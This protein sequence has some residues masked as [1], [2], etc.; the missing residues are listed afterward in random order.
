MEKPSDSNVR[1]KGEEEK[2]EIKGNK[3][4]VIDFIIEMQKGGMLNLV[5]E[6]ILAKKDEEN[7]SDTEQL[8]YRLGERN[9]Q[10]RSV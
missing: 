6:Y 2:N 7:I 4:E 10:F 9:Y 3:E 5:N 1:V 8:E